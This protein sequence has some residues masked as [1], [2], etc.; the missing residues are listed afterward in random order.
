MY[1]FMLSDIIMNLHVQMYTY[2]CI[3]ILLYVYVA[4]IC[5]FQC[6]HIFAFLYI[7]NIRILNMYRNAHIYAYTNIK[8]QTYM[9]LM[10]Y[11]YVYKHVYKHTY[12]YI[13]FQFATIGLYIHIY[14][15][16]CINTYF[17]MH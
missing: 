2:M 1:S 16:I 7:F 6:R 12:I 15:Y 10:F 9:C 3:C 8:F 5:T 17:Q 11:M 14:T 13:C 4:V